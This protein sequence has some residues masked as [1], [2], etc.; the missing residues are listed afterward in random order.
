VRWARDHAV[1]EVL[2]L[3]PFDEENPCAALDELSPRQDKFERA[4][5]RNH[6]ARGGAPPALPRYDGASSYLEG[7]RDALGELGYNRDGKPGKLQ[8]V[9]GLLA[10]PAG[11]T[12]AVRVFAG[13]AADPTTV[14]AQ[15]D[16]VPRQSAIQEVAF[17]SDRGMVKRAGQKALAEAGLHYISASTDPWIRK[18]PAGKTIQMEL[19]AEEVREVDAEEV[20]GAAPQRRS[21]GVATGGAQDRGEPQAEGAIARVGIG[22]LLRHC[23]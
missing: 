15:I 23:R 2:G 6:L 19:F 8:I 3:E 11:E 4:L 17:V 7:E 22:R 10:D 20:A 13:N 16:M 12:M 9:I 21:G 5:W 1:A 18:L 14:A